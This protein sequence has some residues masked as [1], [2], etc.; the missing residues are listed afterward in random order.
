QPAVLADDQLRAANRLR[1]QRIDA[2]ALDL[3]GHEA[4]ADE[5][6]D[7][8]P[9]ER[10]RGEAEIFDDLDLLPGG[11]LAQKIR[12]ADQH[13]GE[14]DQVVEHLVADRLAEHVD[15]DRGGRFHRRAPG[16]ASPSP[17]SAA[18]APGIV[19]C[20]TKKSSSVCRIGFSDTRCAPAAVSSPSSRSG[21]G[22]SGISS[23]YRPS[24]SR[25]ARSTRAPSA[26]TTSSPTPA[27]TISQPPAWNGCISVSRPDATSRPF[28]RM[29]TR[30]QSASASL[31]TWE[32]K[33][34][35]QPRSRNRRMS[36]RT[37]RRPSGSS[38]DIGSSKITSSGSLMIACAMPTRCS[39]PFENLRSCRRRS[40]PMPTSSSRR[41][42]RVR[43][44]APL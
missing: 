5:H 14:Q 27:T 28:A 7:E 17:R 8:E 4:D 31:S 36:A 19:T 40:A 9:K 25:T 32:L 44:S 39:M 12:D 1:Q 33:K 34:T 35:V 2:A 11:Q 21:G 43:L 41:V 26:A 15:R 42:A 22:S 13:H 37:S 10:R 16:F 23:M 38:P 30:L 6:R 3:L 24:P 20:S 29:A 18:P